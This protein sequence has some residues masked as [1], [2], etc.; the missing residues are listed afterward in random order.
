MKS[1]IMLRKLGEYDVPED[2]SR[3]DRGLGGK[4][5]F[6]RH[7]HERIIGEKIFWCGLFKDA[8]VEFTHLCG[9]EFVRRSETP[10]EIPGS[11]MVDSKSVPGIYHYLT[12]EQVKEITIASRRKVIRWEY[13]RKGKIMG[14][15]IIAVDSRYRQR[16]GDQALG[17]YLWIVDPSKKG[18][19]QNYTEDFDYDPDPLCGEKDILKHG[20]TPKSR[21]R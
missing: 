11:T 18:V 10:Y 8:P 20:E 3:V 1:L 12:P 16:R 19:P 5:L 21:R 6:Q 17:A 7:E 13:S 9:I 15:K 14:G 4:S 2:N